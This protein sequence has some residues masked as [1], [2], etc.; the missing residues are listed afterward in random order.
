MVGATFKI[1]D[2][3]MIINILGFFREDSSFFLLP[4]LPLNYLAKPWVHMPCAIARRE[5]LSPYF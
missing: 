3:T 1:N 2:E 5:M 4:D